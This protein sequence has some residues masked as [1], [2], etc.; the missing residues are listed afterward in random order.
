VAIVASDLLLDPMDPGDLVDYSYDFAGAIAD[1]ADATLVVNAVTLADADAAAGLS[2]NQHSV[3]GTT[4]QV[5]LE[6]SSGNRADAGWSGDG[7]LCP[8]KLNVTTGGGRTIERT[9][10][11]RVKQL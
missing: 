9:M 3:S 2:V 1:A 10:R 6:I 7:R 8:V 5:W 4:V 11:V